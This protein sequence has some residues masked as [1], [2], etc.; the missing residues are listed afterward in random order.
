MYIITSKINN[1][2]IKSLILLS[3]VGLGLAKEENSNNQTEISYPSANLTESGNDKTLVF[4]GMPIFLRDPTAGDQ[5]KCGSGFVVITSGDNDRDKCNWGGG[6]GFLTSARCC[7]QLQDPDKR[8][9]QY[10]D[11]FINPNSGDSPERTGMVEDNILI[12]DKRRG[13]DFI[14]FDFVSTLPVVLPNISPIPYVTGDN[15]LYP[16][17][18]LGSVTLGSR[19]CAYGIVSGYR[20]GNMVEFNL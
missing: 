19:V 15:D 2:K 11:V 18:G 1:N 16:V 17:A 5:L 4:G 14:D 7:K 9:C 8:G 12:T 6:A 13:I 10:N 20:C 3:L